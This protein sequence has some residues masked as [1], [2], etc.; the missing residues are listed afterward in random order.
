VNKDLSNVHTLPVGTPTISLSK[1]DVTLEFVVLSEVTLKG[2][3][4]SFCA[5][6][7]KTWLVVPLA[8]ENE[9]EDALDTLRVILSG[10]LTLGYVASFT[11]IGEDHE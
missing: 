3:S 10:F 7:V 4:R 8:Y 9:F 2:P 1:G 5:L 6:V 11:K